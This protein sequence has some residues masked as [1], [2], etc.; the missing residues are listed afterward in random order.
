[1]QDHKKTV[2][3]V[4]FMELELVPFGFLYLKHSNSLFASARSHDLADS[5]RVSAHTCASASCFADRWFFRRPAVQHIVLLL[6]L[7]V[8][9]HF[10]CT[11]S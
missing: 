9:L 8:H 5:D 1:M 10:L 11:N 2:H 3:A 6:L 7:C 4:G